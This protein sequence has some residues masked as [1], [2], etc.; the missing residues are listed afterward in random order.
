MS[1]YYSLG[2]VSAGLGV[3]EL[4]QSVRAAVWES[5][6]VIEGELFLERGYLCSTTKKKNNQEKKYY[7]A[8]P[9]CDLQLLMHL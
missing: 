7:S 1:Y 9:H 3:E 6:R 5:V 4:E 2:R 8:Q